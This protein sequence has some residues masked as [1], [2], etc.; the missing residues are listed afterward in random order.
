MPYLRAKFGFNKTKKMN[1]RITLLMLLV[2]TLGACKTEPTMN[3]TEIGSRGEILI[4]H[5]DRNGFAQAPFSEWFNEQYDNYMPDTVATSRIGE[6]LTDNITVTLVLGTWCGDSQRQVPRFY[7]VIDAVGFDEAKMLVSSVN[8][9]KTNK[10][11]D[12][13]AL[14]IQLVPTFIIYKNNKE[15]GRIIESPIDLLEI[16]MLNII[17]NAL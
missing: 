13:E 16:D 9:S 11:I 4:G 7:K 14:D 17:T 15:I 5:C 1:T 12:A 8:T 2:L 6:L 10:H 3:N